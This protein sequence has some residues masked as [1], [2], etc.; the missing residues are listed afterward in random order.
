MDD[1]INDQM[2]RLLE[3]AQFAGI[4]SAAEL[5]RVLNVSPQTV[6]NWAKRDTGIAREGLLA[7]E[8]IFGVSALWLA[9]GKG[10]PRLADMVPTKPA[11]DETHVSADDVVELMRLF[12]GCDETGRDL[13][14]QIARSQFNES[15]ATHRNS[16]TRNKRQPRR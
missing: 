10:A 8:E 13:I 15:V 14:L 1:A 2:R 5:A 3:V 9:T 4:Q 12:A 11:R 7:A 6:T 16:R